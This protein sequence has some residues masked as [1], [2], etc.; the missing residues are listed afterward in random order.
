MIDKHNERIKKEE[1]WDPEGHYNVPTAKRG[2]VR[3][4]T[5]LDDDSV[6]GSIDDRKDRGK[7]G[8]LVVKNRS[9]KSSDTAS[10]EETIKGPSNDDSAYDTPDIDFYDF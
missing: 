7:L 4:P 5:F 3:D 10:S 6:K 1:A 9:E 2:E 8:E